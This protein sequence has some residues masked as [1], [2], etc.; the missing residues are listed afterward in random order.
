MRGRGCGVGSTTSLSTRHYTRRTKGMSTRG[1]PV[2][3]TTEKCCAYDD[4]SDV[5][6]VVRTTSST[7]ISSLE[8]LYLHNFCYFTWTQ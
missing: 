2:V 1:E 8:T 6:Q 7:S 3:E 5:K 4:C